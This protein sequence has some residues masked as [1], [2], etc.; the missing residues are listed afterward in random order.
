MREY[1][2]SRAIH[3]PIQTYAVS[4]SETGPQARE[5]KTIS[6][7]IPKRKIK[8]TSLATYYIEQRRSL[9][10]E[11]TCALDSRPIAVNLAGLALYHLSSNSMPMQQ[12]NSLLA[13]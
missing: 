2:D 10:D 5:R 7:Q 8:C 1:E 6:S 3:N 13:A 11:E 4:G 9:E 12:N